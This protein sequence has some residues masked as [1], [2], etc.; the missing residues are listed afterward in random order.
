ML[1]PY[2]NR[3]TIEPINDEDDFIPE[4]LK[5]DTLILCKVVEVPSQPLEIKKGDSILVPKA[6]IRSVVIDKQTFHIVQ[7][8]DVYAIYTT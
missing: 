2:E 4:H 1:K 7:T 3:L 8:R 6:S 5:K